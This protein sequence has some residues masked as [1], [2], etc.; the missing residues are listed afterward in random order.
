MHAMATKGL[1]AEQIQSKLVDA[2]AELIKVFRDEL[3]K[4]NVC[5]AAY[6][7]GEALHYYQDSWTESHT[8]R[9]ASGAISQFQDYTEQSPKLHADADY[10]VQGTAAFNAMVARS[11]GFLQFAQVCDVS[12][13]KTEELKTAIKTMFYPITSGCKA[14][15]SL[16]KFLPRNR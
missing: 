13:E 16:D 9:T 3:S 15:G 6:A 8:V 1:T 11:I 5:A 12:E 4:G 7:L 2:T 10:L 14:G